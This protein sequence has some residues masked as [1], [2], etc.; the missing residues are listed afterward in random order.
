MYFPNILFQTQTKKKIQKHTRILDTNRLNVIIQHNLVTTPLWAL[1]LH[2]IL[3]GIWIVC[4]IR[5]LPSM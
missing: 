1:L 5:G 2:I 3:F 4:E